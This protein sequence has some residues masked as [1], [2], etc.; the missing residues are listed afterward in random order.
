MF[1]F[2]FAY[3]V[4]RE[5]LRKVTMNGEKE[6]EREPRHVC[7]KACPRQAKV[8]SYS[9]SVRSACT[10]KIQP[11]RR[12]PYSPLL[13]ECCRRYAQLNRRRLHSPKPSCTARGLLDVAYHAMMALSPSTLPP[14][15]SSPALTS[16]YIPAYFN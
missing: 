12:R 1:H 15:P 6:R 8:T 9:L 11:S 4:G 2:T 16:I 14:P 5:P 10:I 13:R 3:P 7:L